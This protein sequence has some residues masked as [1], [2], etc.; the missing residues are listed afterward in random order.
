MNIKGN[1]IDKTIRQINE[2]TRFVA[3]GNP[4]DKIIRRINE[5]TRFVADVTLF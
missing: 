3:E 5:A 1:P 4:I 2:A